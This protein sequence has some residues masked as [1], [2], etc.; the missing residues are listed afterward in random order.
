M[1]LFPLQ[2]LVKPDVT[3]SIFVLNNL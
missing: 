3:F 2:T 1:F